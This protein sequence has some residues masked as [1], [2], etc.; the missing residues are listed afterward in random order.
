LGKRRVNGGADLIG[1]AVLPHIANDTD[2]LPPHYPA[3]TLVVLV[4]ADALADRVFI[5]PI[6]PGRRLAH[7]GHWERGLVI[8]PGKSPAS[9]K[10]DS[11]RPKISWRDLGT[12]RLDPHS[13]RF[14]LGVA[15]DTH[16]TGVVCKE[17]Y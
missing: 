12:L 13:T 5:R 14:R 11:H 10:R 6:Q 4:D 1:K 9:K 3:L 8:D 17:G 7:D 2:N 16:G 15:L